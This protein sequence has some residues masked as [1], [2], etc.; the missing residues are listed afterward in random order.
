MTGEAMSG[1]AAAAAAPS[2]RPDAGSK[3]P[4]GQVMQPAAAGQTAPAADDADSGVPVDAGTKADADAGAVCVA[5]RCDNKDN[6]CD[7][8][9]DEGTTCA[10]CADSAPTGQGAECDRCVCESCSEALAGCIGTM[11]DE[12]NM[13][14]GNV[15]TCFGKSVQAGL[16]TGPDSDC[17]QNGDGPCAAEFRDAFSRGWACTAD[18]VRTPCGGLTRVRLECYRSKC[19]AVCKA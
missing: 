19:A 3:A 13:L 12:W 10:A 2:A 5:E 17:F 9:V 11:D 16:C 15:L 6:D 8:K 14:C 4:V 18:P 1:M 7:N